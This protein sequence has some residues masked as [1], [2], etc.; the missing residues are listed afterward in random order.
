[1]FLWVQLTEVFLL[2]K[3]QINKIREESEIYA[4][5]PER[6]DGVWD[7]VEKYYPKY[8]SCNDDLCKIVN[9]ELNGDAEKM[10]T[11]EFG[12]NP[13]L[14]TTAFDQSCKYVYERAIVAYQMEQCGKISL[15]CDIF[16][17]GMRGIT[18]V[19]FAWLP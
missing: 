17:V 5:D 4:P 15:N 8:Y 12:E 19:I 9:G 1:M 16:L 18:F 7:F 3:Y 13:E 2:N 10:F 14:A 6:G 11:E